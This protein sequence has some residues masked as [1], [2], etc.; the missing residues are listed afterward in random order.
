MREP[1]AVENVHLRLH[2]M[3]ED[4]AVDAAVSELRARGQR[5]TAPRYAVLVAL[6][7][8]DDYLTADEIAAVVGGDDAHRATVY[9]T[10]DVLADTGIVLSRHE[11]GGATSYHFATRTKGHEH[12]HGLCRVCG[13]VVSL[14]STALHEAISTVESTSGFAVELRHVTFSGVCVECKGDRAS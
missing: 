12:L 6:A 8:R 9:R 11:P 10:L 2:L 5:I 7:S 1:L 14:P 13:V 4:A 3:F